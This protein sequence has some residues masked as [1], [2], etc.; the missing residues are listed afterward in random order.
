LS[1]FAC[2]VIC[3]SLI[4]SPIPGFCDNDDHASSSSG[5]GAGAAVGVLVIGLVIWA[6]FG[7]KNSKTEQA[8]EAK[9]AST[10]G[11]ATDVRPVDTGIG[12]TVKPEF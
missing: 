11:A 8:S 9:P 10:P 12:S 2:Y 1:K 3:A 5:G 4:C 6:L 7:N